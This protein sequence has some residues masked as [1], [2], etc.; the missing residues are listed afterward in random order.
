MRVI[1]VQ[2]SDKPIPKAISEY[3]RVT[4]T[5]VSTSGK[6]E[7][8]S[9]SNILISEAE[10]WVDVLDQLEEDTHN[11]VIE[12]VAPVAPAKQRQRAND[13]VSYLIL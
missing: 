6:A 8:V 5:Q 10:E 9:T 12:N 13:S 1:T 11:P 4:K 7:K 3:A 2:D